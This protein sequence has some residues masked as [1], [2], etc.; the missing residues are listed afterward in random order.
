ME[1]T[2]LLIKVEKLSQKKLEEMSVTSWPVWECGVSEFDW[3]YEEEEVCQILQGSVEVITEW[4]NVEIKPGDFV[5][6]PK[7]LNCFWKVLEPV[8]KH[9]SFNK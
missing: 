3:T 8:K 6:F 9:Y 1:Q 5:T 2:A 7:G 4:Q